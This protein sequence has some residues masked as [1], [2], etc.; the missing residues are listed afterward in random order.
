MP[1]E[2]EIEIEGAG[3]RAFERA[4]PS[5]AQVR[6]RPRKESIAKKR[7]E[8]LK[9]ISNEGEQGSVKKGGE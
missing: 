7:G 4:R 2:A 3:L 8:I 1:G 9:R 6:F 5:P